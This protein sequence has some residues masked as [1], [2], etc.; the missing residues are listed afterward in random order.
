MDTLKA[1]ECRCGKI[2]LPPRKRCIYCTGDMHEIE[3]RGTGSLISYTVL[4]T[5][6]EGFESPLILGLIELDE[7]DTKK[8]VKKPRIF[9]SGR[10]T[11]NE[12]KIGLKVKIVELEDRYYFT[13]L[14]KKKEKSKY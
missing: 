13:S 8:G 6:P 4:N 1:S 14:K 11:E 2:L 3:I 5:T 9:C 10:I 12:L 7:I